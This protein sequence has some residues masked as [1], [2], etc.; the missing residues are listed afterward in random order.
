MG[1]TMVWCLHQD[2]VQRCAHARRRRRPS[3]S[4]DGI[5]VGAT[6]SGVPLGSRAVAAA[7]SSTSGE[8][9]RRRWGA[10]AG[11][12]STTAPATSSMTHGSPKD[13][14]ELLQE[15]TKVACTEIAGKGG[16]GS[17]GNMTSHSYHARAA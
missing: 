15:T 13:R 7:S 1:R 6:G 9:R 5:G 17:E 8:A 11:I 16:V 10:T 4:G 12:A 3:A 2:S 14:L